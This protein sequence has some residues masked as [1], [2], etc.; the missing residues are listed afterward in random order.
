MLETELA[1][2]EERIQRLLAAYHQARL[3]RRRA[4][5]DRDRLVALNNELRKRIEGVI[6]RIKS[7]ETEQ[8]A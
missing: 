6:H 2:L 8:G 3:E 4:L 5:Q 1:Q 7:L